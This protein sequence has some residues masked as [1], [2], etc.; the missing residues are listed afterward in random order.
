[1][2]GVVPTA[3]STGYSNADVNMD[4]IIKYAGAHNDRDIILQ[5][6]G[7]TMPMAVRVEQTP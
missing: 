4:G 6:V 5:T 1:L 7:G 2:G 3:T